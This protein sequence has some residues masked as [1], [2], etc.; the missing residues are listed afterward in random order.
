MKLRRLRPR[1]PRPRTPPPVVP[2]WSSHC[3]QWYDNYQLSESD[4]YQLSEK[5]NYQWKILP[6][7]W[8]VEKN[9][10]NI[11]HPFYV[12]NTCLQLEA[13]SLYFA[14]HT[15]MKPFSTMSIILKIIKYYVVKATTSSWN[16]ECRMPTFI[17]LFKSLNVV[18]VSCDFKNYYMPAIIIVVILK[19]I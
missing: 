7:I 6:V 8:K 14:F 12:E 4:K 11:I 2:I 3:P 9:H 15:F 19:V 5:E 17:Y 16:L 10:L 1:R 18:I 13:L